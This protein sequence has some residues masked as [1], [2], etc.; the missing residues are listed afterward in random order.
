MRSKLIT[1]IILLLIFSIQLNAQINFAN[2][3][4]EI[5]IGR[6]SSFYNNLQSEQFIAFFKIPNFNGNVGKIS[7]E[8]DLNF[9]YILENKKT[10]YLVGFA[11]MFRYDKKIHNADLILKAGIGANY[12]SRTKVGTRTL[13]GHFI[14]SNMISIG[15][16]VV[17]T[18]NF[19]I[20]ISYLLRH[21]SNAGIYDSNEGFNSHYL[22]LSLII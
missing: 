1:I 13:G 7:Y 18:K 9:E 2:P 20:E 12:L 22:I 11:P 4:Y 19:V 6:G 21:I 10:T 14:F 16:R 8:G 15:A 3:C 17:N 5:S